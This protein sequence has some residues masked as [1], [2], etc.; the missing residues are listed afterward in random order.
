M[1]DFLDFAGQHPFLAFCF[2]AIAGQVAIYVAYA[3]AI[4]IRGK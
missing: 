1:K 4:I 2:V 3:I